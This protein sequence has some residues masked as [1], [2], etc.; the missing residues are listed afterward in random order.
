MILLASNRL[1]EPLSVIGAMLHGRA[2]VLHKWRS[3]T[4][5]CSRLGELEGGGDF[6]RRHCRVSFMQ[7]HPSI[8]QGS[9]NAARQIHSVCTFLVK[10]YNIFTL[11]SD[12]NNS[13]VQ[14]GGG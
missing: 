6:K 7:G 13:P 9:E 2:K 4:P 10:K 1:R 11:P 14:G 3:G 12:K 5:C 8:S